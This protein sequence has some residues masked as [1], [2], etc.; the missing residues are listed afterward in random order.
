MKL[1][2]ALENG[3]LLMR[4]FQAVSE[5]LVC[6]VVWVA[7]VIDGFISSHIIIWNSHHSSVYFVWYIL[8]A[9]A[10]ISFPAHSCLPKMYL[11]LKK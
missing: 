9:F 11:S 1:L 10:V 6:F 7:A 3:Y 8:G 5:R 2:L 4:L